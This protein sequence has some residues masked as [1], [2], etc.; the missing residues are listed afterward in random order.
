MLLRPTRLKTLRLSITA[1]VVTALAGLWLGGTRVSETAHAQVP[2][3]T[4]R[5]FE[6]PQVHPLAVTPDGTRLLAVNSPN[7]TL[8][9]FQ[10]SGSA[11]PTLI[12]EIP[13]GLEP[14]SVAA[15]NDR[16]AWV[17][18]WLSDSVS[19]VDLAAGN[20]VRT[21]DVG[22]E[23]TDILFAGTNDSRAFVCV[24]GGGRLD[25]DGFSATGASG[26]VKAFDTAN[27]SAPPQ[28]VEVFG[29][30]P[31]AL[32]RDASGSRVF[33]SVFESGNQTTLVPEKVTRANGGL[34][35]PQPAM[36]AGLPAAPN[37]ALVVRWN[38]AAW[39]DETGN[40]KWDQFVNYTLAD[41]D[42]VTIDASGANLSV[43]A[44]SRNLGTHMGNMAFDNGSGRLFVVNLD[45]GNVRRFE[46]NL[47]GQFQSNR[48][49]A[50]DT[51]N[52]A[53]SLAFARD[54]NA[55]VDFSNTAGTDAE[56]AQSLALPSDIARASDG[57]LYVAAT[58]SAK[59]GVLDAA[60]NV[61]AR[62]LVGN[63]PTGLALDERRGRLY[64]LN[65]HDQTVSVVNT[66]ARTQVLVVPVGFN[67]EQPAVR[68]GRRFLYDA[69]NFSAHGTVSCASCHPSGHRDGLAW[70]LGDP[71]GAMVDANL[72]MYHPMKGPM[73]TQSLRGLLD[74]EPLHWRAD[75]RDVTEFN[76]TFTDLLGSKRL[77]TTQEMA[78]F[79]A[80]VNTLAYPPNPN[81]NHDR[82]FPDPPA[83]PN[84]DTG[85]KRFS[86]APGFPSVA[87]ELATSC[88]DCHFSFTGV[89][90]LFFMGTFGHVF[91][92]SILSEPQAFK[93]P[94][95]RG[96]YQKAGMR[97]PAPGQP[98]AEQLAGFGFMHD[99]AFD[100]LVN[101]LR[102]PNF[103]GFNNDDE[104]R[105]IAAFLLSTD[106]VIAPAV[107]LQ[108]TVGAGNKNSPEVL[109]R[110]NLLLQ[111]AQRIPIPND[112]NFFHGPGCDLVVRG[113]YGGE[114]RGFLRLQN[115][116]FQ[117]DSASEAPVTLQQL[118]DAVSPGSELT[119]TGV[120]VGEGR[121]F[122][123]DQ[124]GDGLFDNDEARTSVQI[125]GRVVGADGAGVAGV[126]VALSGSQ[127]AST[128][129][130]AAG[131]YAFNS[132]STV[133]TH[134]VTPLGAGLTFAPASAT[135]VKP[136]W[137]GSAVFVTSTTANASDSSQFFVA[138]HYGDFLSREP[139]AE[140]L[141]FW[142]NEIES[143]GSNAQCR[144][145]K[146]I[147][148]SAAFFLSIESQQ[149]G[150]LTYKTYKASFGDLPSRPVPVTF[151]QLMADAQ[152]IGRG[153]VVGRANWEGL[154]EA[155][156]AAFFA[157]WV[158]RP[159]F[160]SRYPASLSA[161]DFVNA[162]N[163]NAGFPL[164]TSERDVLAGQ[165]A[166]N[167]N[168]QGRAA[169]LRQLAEHPE[170]SRREL[171]RAFVLTQY[172]GYLRR[173]PD[174][175]PEPNLDFTGYNFWLGKL[176]EFDGNFVN[177]EMVKAFITSLEYRRRFGQ[178]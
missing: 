86:A 27:L 118:L 142:V 15:R 52:G 73:T 75:R 120:P 133:G 67:P 62:V 117:P 53:P 172:F 170:L 104:R 88:N 61:A 171:N 68:N 82:T 69:V 47:R 105:D 146:R 29:K 161:L 72:F 70:D 151:G 167:N 150:F 1:L 46:P 23:P 162:L 96:I 49:S 147:N 58:S 51:A 74:A 94:Q 36:A 2:A 166:A 106:S 83:G 168:A 137:N 57:T 111:Q 130:D 21:I 145:V 30:Q 8:S 17:V 87:L 152:R 33:V 55:H 35:A 173:N 92:G 4:F 141:Q 126:G 24:S 157:G 178:P 76:S 18:N 108:V 119:F 95:L 60:G 91:S 25:I 78:D 66:A 20:V 153:V 16:E 28:V 90:P 77:L 71:T 99:G 14:V 50:L 136:T 159:E 59:V 174:E 34:P 143:C 154:L 81:E 48:V 103:H 134:T 100:T 135:F 80:F 139:D 164:N 148:V 98:R 102:Q 22:D 9:V 11:P 39:A 155:N 40:T 131:R 19:V 110:L 140:G 26:A 41:I 97:K 149:T 65:R 93:V 31:R 165:L 144:E 5:N 112:P 10:L 54:L 158:Q 156:K 124:D 125:A 6:S 44:Q 64:V 84:A 122:A 3:Q 79:V 129:T 115:E 101:F 45:S 56:R 113:I 38:G 12:A 109:A 169:A 13:V 89:P 63:G 138:Q 128:V 132:V 32:A 127:T 116:T 160:V 43:S 123:L 37:T 177:A 42:L 85:S 114:R 107:G 163:A 176:N 7:A 175:A 121:R